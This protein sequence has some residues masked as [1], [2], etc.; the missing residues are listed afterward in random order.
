MLR[1]HFLCFTCE[2]KCRSECIFYY[3]PVFSSVYC[4]IMKLLTFVPG[5]QS[6]QESFLHLFVLLLPSLILT[7]HGRRSALLWIRFC[8]RVFTTH[9]FL[10]VPFFFTAECLDLCK[11]KYSMQTVGIYTKIEFRF[12]R[13]IRIKLQYI[14]PELGILTMYRYWQVSIVWCMSCTLIKKFSA[15]KMLLLSLMSKCL[16]SL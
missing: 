3:P 16:K 2:C 9:P 15:V 7:G 10:K 12:I 5:L 8:W 14:H 11:K 6:K 13:I 1:V 4:L